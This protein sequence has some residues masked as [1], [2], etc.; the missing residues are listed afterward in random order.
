M[1][2]IYYFLFV[3]LFTIASCKGKSEKAAETLPDSEQTASA[4]TAGES[5]PAE[6]KRYEIKSGKVVYNGPMG[7]IQTLYFDNYGALETFTT[8]LEMMGVKSKDCQIRRDGYQYSFKE[9][10]TTGTKSAWY[11]NDMNYSKMDVKLMERYKVKDLGTETIAGKNCR[12]FSAEFGSSPMTTWVWNN[13]MVKTITKMGNGEMVI[14]AASI[15]E[16]PVDAAVFDIPE[17]I[18]FTEV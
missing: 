16:C 1:K 8:E 4:T 15:E 10:E 17:T 7:V 18:T 12:K 14:E 13:I 9:G 3:I 5:A 11:T 2:T 6:K